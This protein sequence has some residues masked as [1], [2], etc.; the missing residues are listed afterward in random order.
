LDD[1]WMM[2]GACR[3]QWQE[4]VFGPVL[5]VRSFSTEAEA[6]VEANSTPFGLASTVMSADMQ[7][8]ARVANQIRAGAVYA[9]VRAP[10]FWFNVTM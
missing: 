10:S 4:E 1:D 9:T 3:S 8:A 7:R 6:V 2:V 5:V